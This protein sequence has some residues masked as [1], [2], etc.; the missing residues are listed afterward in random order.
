MKK[1]DAHAHI[2]Y[3]GG[4]ADVGITENQ[5]LEQMEKFDIEKTALCCEDNE[6]TL[7]VMERHPGKII[8]CIYVNPFNLQSVENMEK[9]AGKGFSAVKLNPLRH[10]YCA[11]GDLVDPIMEKAYKLSLPVCIHSGHPPYSL[12]WQ[13]G[14]L[15]ERH[16]QV[17]IMMIHMGHG[18]G[19]YI[20]AAI[21][22]ARKFPNIYL[23]MSGMPMPSKIK[24]AYGTVGK[25]RIM[26]GTDTP[27][28]HPSVEIQ[29]ILVSGVGDEGVQRIFY[30]N[31]EEFFGL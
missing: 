3:I 6:L 16:P 13:I 7:E 15:S 9:Y 4:W 5:L 17:K 24:E 1:I 20:D 31:A 12:P 25:H 22:M 8:G 23:E 11:D 2:G 27:F 18:H 14:L 10:A 19:V 21:K 26:F 28:H 29:K 30:N